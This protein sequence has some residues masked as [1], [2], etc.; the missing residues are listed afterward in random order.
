MTREALTIEVTRSDRETA[1]LLLHGDLDFETAGLIDAAA[2]ARADGY[3]HLVVELS[4]LGLCDSSGLTALI[5]MFQ[6]GRRTGGSVR[7]T[8]VGEQ[9]RRLLNR[10]GLIGMFGVTDGSS[11]DRPADA[12]SRIAG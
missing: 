12:R 5:E 2:A 7:L 4:R 8:G 1:R 10:T 11:G 9:L 3:H 6:V